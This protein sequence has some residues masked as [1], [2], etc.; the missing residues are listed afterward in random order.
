MSNLPPGEG[1][2]LSDKEALSDETREV[3]NEE[4]LR[5]LELVERQLNDAYDQIKQRFGKELDERFPTIEGQYPKWMP[6]SFFG[7]LDIIQDYRGELLRKQSGAQ[8]IT[9]KDY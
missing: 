4:I 1:R 6:E 7:A 8:S 5:K 2:A 3:S 9:P